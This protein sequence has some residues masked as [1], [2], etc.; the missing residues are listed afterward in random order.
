MMVDRREGFN[1]GNEMSMLPY[2]QA[3]PSTY[4]PPLSS[5]TFMINPQLNNM[6]ERDQMDDQYL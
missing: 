1:I 3:F 6:V 5:S 2:N 4:Y